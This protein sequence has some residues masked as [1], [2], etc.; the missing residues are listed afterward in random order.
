M[1]V[2]LFDTICEK[3]GLFSRKLYIVSFLR[4]TTLIKH[5]FTNVV[6]PRSNGTSYLCDS[7]SLT[8]MFDYFMHRVPTIAMENVDFSTRNIISSYSYKFYIFVF[9][10]PTA[11]IKDSFLHSTRSRNIRISYFLW[12]PRKTFIFHNL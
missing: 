4:D 8:K 9:L 7:V 3:D 2:A 5:S 11:L 12:F 6:T 1:H 10:R